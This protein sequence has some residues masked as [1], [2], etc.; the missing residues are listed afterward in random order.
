MYKIQEPLKRSSHAFIHLTQIHLMWT[1][2]REGPWEQT[3]SSE[4][5]DVRRINWW[6]S[7]VVRQGMCTVPRNQFDVT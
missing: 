7:F 1:G 3:L 6:T 2:Q 5:A 4:K